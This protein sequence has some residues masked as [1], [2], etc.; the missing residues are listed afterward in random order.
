MAEFCIQ[1]FLVTAVWVFIAPRIMT[2]QM[3]KPPL[4]Y[5]SWTTRLRQQ[6]RDHRARMT[7]A[8][9]FLPI[10]VA[11]MLWMAFEK[12]R[13]GMLVFNGLLIGLALLMWLQ[14]PIVDGGAGALRNF[15]HDPT[16]C[17]A[18]GQ[19]FDPE[20]TAERCGECGWIVPPDDA[21]PE[22]A[23]W[24]RRGIHPQGER[25]VFDPAHA[26]GEMKQVF[27]M[28][29]ILIVGLF[30]IAV[31]FNEAQFMGVLAGQMGGMGVL[32]GSQ[33]LRLCREIRRRQT[34]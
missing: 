17:G 4:R 24:Y 32:A 25:M 29:V 23:N 15:R 33:W 20:A 5:L 7:I 6:W 22:P 27:L 31:A 16:R 18:C 28:S 21:T 3:E 30:A 26:A 14:R 8:A 2:K 9:I 11:T 10:A 19:F 1:F 13:A 12:G 34:A